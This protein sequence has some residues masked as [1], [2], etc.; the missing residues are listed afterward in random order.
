MYRGRLLGHELAKALPRQP[1]AELRL[2]HHRRSVKLKNRLCQI[3]SNYRIFHYGCRP[4]RSVAFN[5]TF[6]AHCDAVWEAATTPSH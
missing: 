6:L 5:T 4:F 3:H 1:L 2:P